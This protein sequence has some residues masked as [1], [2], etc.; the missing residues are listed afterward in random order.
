[1][2]GSAAG[3]WADWL[4]R[5]RDAQSGT[6]GKARTVSA[7]NAIR[8]RVLAGARIA[9]GDRVVDLGA[10]TG[11]LACGAVELVGPG[12][13]VIAID[14]STQAL[15]RLPATV[16]AV[17]GSARRLPLHDAVADAVVIRSVLIYLPDLEAVAREAAR[18]LRP[19]GRLS[20]FEPVNA[21]RAH[22]AALEGFTEAELAGLAR[23]QAD[24]GEQSRTMLAFTPSRLRGAL[25]AAGF[26]LHSAE[27]EPHR[28]RL[29][30]EAAAAAYL[31]QR[32]HAGAATV[33]ELA[34]A[35]WGAK[36][37]ERY[38]NAWLQAARTQGAITFTTPTLYCTATR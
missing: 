2:T 10:G 33:L 1:M 24:S 26:H 28:Q 32:G 37:A 16:S 13:S 3:Q 31:D 4:T 8:G 15:S 36:G 19:G 38:R 21:Q 7:L 30:G 9:P 12:G 29:A 14:P 22:D 11:L 18:V 6:D 27:L 23:A 17:A 5:E 25:E 20:L 35:L 34:T